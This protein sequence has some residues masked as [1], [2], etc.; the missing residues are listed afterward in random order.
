M[1]IREYFIQVQIYRLQSL[2]PGTF[3]LE[4]RCH[5][6]CAGVFDISWRPRCSTEVRQAE[7]ADTDDC[8]IH[9]ETAL[10][11]AVALA[12]GSCAL[13]QTQLETE[14]IIFQSSGKDPGC[15]GM[16]LSCDWNPRVGDEVICSYSDGILCRYVVED[17]CIKA[18]QRWK[19][20]DM[21]T[22]VA[23]WATHQVC[24]EI[25]IPHSIRD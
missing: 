16:T 13:V 4:E 17:G 12:D 3:K 20:H 23:S 18:A 6:D 5:L 14:T 7:I 25:I 21:E 19:A 9:E 10:Q 24:R 1:L 11:A 8:H 2:S 15:T 22:W